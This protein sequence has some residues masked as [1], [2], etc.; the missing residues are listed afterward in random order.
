M[1]TSV[2]VTLLYVLVMFKALA[3]VRAAPAG[4]LAWLLETTV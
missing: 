4:T 2:P 1:I 3:V